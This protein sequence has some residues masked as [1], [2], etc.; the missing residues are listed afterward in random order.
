MASAVSNLPL[1]QSLVANALDTPNKS[2]VVYAADFGYNVIQQVT[3]IVN[4]GKA[5]KTDNAK[6]QVAKLGSMAIIAPIASNSLSGSLLTV[7]LTVSNDNFRL[8]DIV[9]DSN[10]V[11]GQVVSKTS[12]SITMIRVG[13]SWTAATEFIA[14]QY[15]KVLFDASKNYNSGG[16]TGLNYVPEYDYNFTSI[17]RESGY[18]G[19]RDQIGTYAQWKNGFW[20]TGQEEMSRRSLG[21]QLEFKYMFSER[22][23]LNQGNGNETYTTGGV[24]W[25]IKNNG[26]N[27]YPLSN[28]LNTSQWHDILQDFV[29]KTANSGRKV[30]ALMGSDA[31]FN[32][33][34]NITSDFVKQSGKNNTFGGESVMGLDVKSYAIGGLEID[35][36]R[37]P[38][39]DDPQ[40]FP[41]ASAITG[42]S[43]MSHTICLL[44]LT[45]TPAADGSGMVAPIQRHYFGDNGDITYKFIPGMIGSNGEQT[46]SDKDGMSF[47]FL[48]DD[49]LYVLPEKMGWVELTS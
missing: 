11:Q 35:F 14:G 45:P 9:A 37:Y 33:Q 6:F 12:T 27:Y 3:D 43:K 21:R 16:K 7:N 31:M 18:L 39:F 40:F 13:G 49:G 26:G 42:K 20:Y 10:L 22:A 17:T 34:G 5:T 38:L 19:R 32:I 30:V 47:E 2:K 46:T 25:S 8:G 23:I 44:D 48:T 28:T 4:K 15:A 24:R 36:V 41:E 1:N 29:S